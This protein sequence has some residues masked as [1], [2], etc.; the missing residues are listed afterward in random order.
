MRH[1]AHGETYAHD[2]QEV[3]RLLIQECG[4]EPEEVFYLDVH[5]NIG[6]RKGKKF[7]AGLIEESS[8]EYVLWVEADS[9]QEVEEILHEAGIKSDLESKDQ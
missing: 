2:A 3:I 1:T 4:C 7:R 8:Q 9:E 6:I 5:E